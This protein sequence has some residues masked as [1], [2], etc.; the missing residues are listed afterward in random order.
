MIAGRRRLPGDPGLV[1][2]M[3]LTLFLLAL[4]YLIFVA[5]L[6]KLGVGLLLIAPLVLVLLGAQ[7]WFSDRLVLMAVGARE[8]GEQEAPQLHDIVSRLAQMAGIPKPRVAIIDSAVPNAL[9]TGR[10]PRHSVVAVTR[11]LMERLEPPEVEAV[12]AHELSH[13]IHRDVGIMTMAAFFATLASFI[14]QMGLWGGLGLGG[15]DDRDRGGGAAVVVLVVSAA[16]W[17]VSFFLIRS[18]SRY[19]E[20]SADRGS[21]ILTGH[22]AALSSALMKISDVARQVPNRD[23]R[24]VEGASA[25]WIFPAFSRGSLSEIFSTHPSLEHRI[26]R[27]E[28]LEG[29][30]G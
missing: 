3:V 9:A 23:L 6:L 12:L 5:V 17:V 24:E 16:V 25:L 15:R 28:R 7:Y 22:P 19:R 10:D 8:V 14:V 18:L 27:L 30:V 29:G 13:V 1:A 11:G 21:A 20:Y 4:V 26:Q 2:H